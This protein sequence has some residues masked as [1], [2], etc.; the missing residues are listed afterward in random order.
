LNPSTDLVFPDPSQA[1]IIV[2]GF[3]HIELA[4][5][6]DD[7]IKKEESDSEEEEENKGQEK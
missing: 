6:E 5:G 7:L 2:D 4:K 1:V 3:D